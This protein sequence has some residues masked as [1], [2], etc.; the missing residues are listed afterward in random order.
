MNDR[1]VLIVGATGML[2]SQI[3]NELLNA[4]ATLRT[5]VRPGGYEGEKADAVN[6]LRRRGLETFEA[7]LSE[8]DTLVPALEGVDTVV[9]ALQGLGAVIVDAQVRLLRAAE[10]AGVRR[11]IPSDFSVD[12][13]NVPPGENRNFDLRRTFAALLD[14][15]KVKGT[16]ILNGAFTDMLTMGYPVIHANEGVFD[17][18]GDG[19]QPLDF[20]SV[21]DTARYT[22]AAVMEVDTPRALRFAADSLTLHELHDR[23]ETWLGKSLEKRSRGS[24]ADLADEVR[25][26]MAENPGDPDS[27][28]PVWQGLQYLHNMV[29]GQAKLHPLDNE[30]YPHVEAE[31]VAS[32]L[33]HS[34]LRI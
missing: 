9:S 17:I 29:S 22:A 10:K 14:G 24:I 32:F 3:A 25:R 21:A 20:T 5:I 11:M 28:F 23:C 34:D 4:G 15:S 26:Q 12:L 13:F 16:S 30:R 19:Q 8:P 18:W 27:G 2:G 31:D 6:A 7:D 33:S 1:P